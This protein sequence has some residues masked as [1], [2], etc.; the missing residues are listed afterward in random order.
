MS[1]QLLVPFRALE[2]G[3]HLNQMDPAMPRVISITV[4]SNN[5]T[6]F[7]SSIC[8]CLLVFNYGHTRMKE[9]SEIVKALIT[10][11]NDYCVCIVTLSVVNR[12][13]SS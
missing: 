3:N 9:Q 4:M 8:L 13:P 1:F 5:M 2:S 10:S 11:I 7:S 12:T 6:A